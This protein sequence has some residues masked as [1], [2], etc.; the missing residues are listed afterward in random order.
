[1]SEKYQIS[2]FYEFK[3][4]ESIR[5]LEDSKTLI[6]AAMSDRSIRGTVILAAEGFNVT[7]S[8]LADDV[9]CF[10]EILEQIFETRLFPKTSFHN[11]AP[12]G[13]IDVKIRNEIVTLRKKVDVS[14][15]EGTHVSAAQWNELLNQEDVVVLD[16][17]NDYEYRNGTFR[18]AVNP[19]TSSFSELPAFIEKN[20]DRFAG[21]KIAMFCTGGIRCEKF[22]PYLISKGLSDVFQLDGGI[23]RYLQ[24]IDPEH[25]LWEGECFVFD[26]R[27]TVDSRLEKGTGPDYSQPISLEGETS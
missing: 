7:V 22:A 20:I 26:S 9:P 8:G 14:L 27:R 11:E 17:R 3:D 4:L 6:C 18:G 5:P 1:M 25:S 23:L 21:K 16:T 12:F 13:K 2:A 24:D 15:G 19:K 10:L